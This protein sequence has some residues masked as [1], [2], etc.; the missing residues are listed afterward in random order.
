[1]SANFLKRDTAGC[2]ALSALHDRHKQRLARELLV[3]ATKPILQEL[4]VLRLP[5]D[6][7]ATGIEQL[8]GRELRRSP[9]VVFNKFV[10]QIHM[11][12]VVRYGQLRAHAKPIDRSSAGK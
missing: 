6:L 11:R 12:C 10:R 7:F 9:P 1:M 4:P 5:K 3:R 8:S 2:E